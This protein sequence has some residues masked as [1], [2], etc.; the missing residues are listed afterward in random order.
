MKK[1]HFL[2]DTQ[3]FEKIAG[4]QFLTRHGDYLWLL[5]KQAKLVVEQESVSDDVLNLDADVIITLGKHFTHEVLKGRKS[6]KLESYAG[7]EHNIGN[8]KICIPWFSVAHL[9]NRGKDLEI[10]TINLF[11]EIRDKYVAV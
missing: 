2:S 9:L 4:H 8:N 3:I 6:F 7:N 10:E 5:F 1:L 11:S